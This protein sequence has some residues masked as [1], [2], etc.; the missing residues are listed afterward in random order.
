MNSNLLYYFVIVFLSYSSYADAQ[1]I[2]QTN[3]LPEDWNIGWAIDASD[4]NNVLFSAGFEL[5]HTTN[6][7]NLWNKIE[8]PDT[9]METAIHVSI[10]GES[11]FWVAT[12]LGK[13][14]G[15]T[16]AGKSWTVR[17][18]D[19]SK[20]QFMNYI[21]MFD[22]MNGIAMGD[23]PFPSQK[24]P[25]V[26]LRTTDGGNTW[27][28]SPDT[29]LI[30]VWSGDTWRR[31]DFVSSTIGYF[32]E[33]GINPQKLLKTIDG[34]EKWLTTNYSGN[35]TVIKCFDENIVLIHSIVPTKISRTTDGENSWE[36]S[37][38]TSGWGNDFEFIPGNA[39]KVFFTDHD[40]LFFSSDTGKTWQEVFVDTIELKGRDIVFPD[41]YHGWILGDSGRVYKT[42]TGGILTNTENN[43]TYLPDKFSLTQNYPN[44]FNPS[45]KI[46][47]QLSVSSLVR[48]KVYD[49]LGREVATLVNEE[50][51]AGKYEVN[52]DASKLSSGVYFYR[53]QAG[54]FIRTKKMIVLK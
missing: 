30:D 46:S 20:T 5:F 47:W 3:G 44:P 18:N 11:H 15:T 36:G 35:A 7:G 49:V 19:E 1:W 27:I 40:K 9:I 38:F 8:L 41:Q 13:I 32:Y 21:E 51:P 42:N 23:A 50:K 45:T 4:S 31:L 22:E 12:D 16:D 29:T 25:A 39:S 2:R 48:I 37:N 52:F 53:L 28:Q 33:S 10:I 26:F 6:G 17:F 54:D 34:C 43:Y 24:K 14:I